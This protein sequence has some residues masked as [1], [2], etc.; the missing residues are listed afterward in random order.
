[1]KTSFGKGV[2]IGLIIA[3]SVMGCSSGESGG[4]TPQEPVYHDY[5]YV[6]NRNSFNI[7][8]YALD[9]S[10]GALTGIAGSPFPAGG[11]PISI[12]TIRIRR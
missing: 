5:A 10:S 11:R 1:M 8:G 7:S 4:D 2:L 9:S 3:V 12:A 6:S